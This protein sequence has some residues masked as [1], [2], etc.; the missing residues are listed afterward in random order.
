MCHK[1]K[2]AIPLYKDPKK[3]DMSIKSHTDDTHTRHLALNPKTTLSLS[4]ALSKWRKWIDTLLFE[5]YN[6]KVL[7]NILLKIA[8]LN[9]VHQVPIQRGC[10][11]SS[12]TFKKKLLNIRFR[13][14]R[15][16]RKCLAWWKWS[17]SQNVMFV[18]TIDVKIYVCCI[19]KHNMK[20]MKAWKFAWFIVWIVTH[21]L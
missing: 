20:R 3:F 7:C 5:S 14:I 8:T 15:P 9:T 11:P 19:I 10:I 6:R 21:R 18:Q 1:N 17:Q 2:Y 13:W 16:V 4:L 12:S